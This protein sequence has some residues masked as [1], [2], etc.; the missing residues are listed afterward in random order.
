MPYITRED[1]NRFV[2][3]SYRDVISAKRK[4]LLKKEIL[5]LSASYGEYITLRRKDATRYEVA[6]SPD[7]GYLLG[8]SV[9]HNFKRPIDMVYCE[10]IPNT[11]EAILVVV[12]GGSVYLDGQFPID[13]IPEELVVFRTQQNHFEIFVYGDIP[14]SQ[15]PVDGKFSFDE[16]S[17][18][19]F[20]ILDSP[21]FPTLPLVKPFQLQ[22]VD[23][24]L[25]SQ[26]IGVFPIKPILIMVVVIGGI[27]GLIEFLSLHKKA[28]PTVVVGVVNPYQLYTDTL[29]SPAPDNEIR[30]LL[31]QIN[32]L[33]SMPGWTAK[34]LTY[35]EGTAVAT[36][37]SQGT[38]VA[39]LMKWAKYNYATVNISPS[40]ITVEIS[41]PLLSREAPTTINALQDVIAAIIDRVSSIIPGN[42]VKLGSYTRYGS[43]TQ[44]PITIKIN[45]MSPA[46]LGL[47]AQQIK[48]LP[49][50]LSDVSLTV[51]QGSL[52][53]TLVFQALGS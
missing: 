49:L 46:V 39:T 22:L 31:Q 23:P 12:K 14:I 3:P 20:T 45:E 32:L 52:S 30:S 48:G 16:S 36:V 1:G 41:F 24:V 2:I 43:F 37:Q 29:T 11:V 28:L 38:K 18:K 35:S 8:E 51:N 6:F 19:S 25:K 21:V 34:T 13:S 53:G 42:N 50:V 10:A 47:L 40:S 27:W 33:L 26:G 4:S 7:A 44:V 15:I 17:V 9:W 5:A